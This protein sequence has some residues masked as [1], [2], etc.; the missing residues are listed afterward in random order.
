MR[1]G[2]GERV[3]G[4]EGATTREGQHKNRARGG[5]NESLVN[6]RWSEVRT[7]MDRRVK[8]GDRLPGLG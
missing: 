7:I 2:E 1:E 4:E 5:A 6:Q 8:R 3:K